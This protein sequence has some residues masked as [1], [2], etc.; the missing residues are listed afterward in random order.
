MRRYEIRPLLG[1]NAYG[2][3]V[4][5]F[6]V[7]GQRAE[8][9]LATELKPFAERI[10]RELAR[11][12]AGPPELG[13]VTWFDA[14]PFLFVPAGALPDPRPRPAPRRPAPQSWKPA[15]GQEPAAGPACP[16]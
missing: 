14:R 8:G 1:P 9:G 13:G 15:R 7:E 10:R 6:D 16:F 5:I 11:L 2:P 3:L 12:A 4:G